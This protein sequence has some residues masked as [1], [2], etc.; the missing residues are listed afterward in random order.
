MYFYWFH[1]AGR[2]YNHVGNLEN[3]TWD[4]DN[5]LEDIKSQRQVNYSDLVWKHRLRNGNGTV[6]CTLTLYNKNLRKV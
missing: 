5:C 6:Q 1:F 4:K 3:F 2:P